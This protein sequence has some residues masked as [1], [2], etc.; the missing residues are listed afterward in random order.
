M[1]VARLVRRPSLDGPRVGRLDPERG[2]VSP[3]EGSAARLAEVD[4]LAAALGREPSERESVADGEVER[5]A[6]GGCRECRTRDDGRDLVA[7]RRLG[8]GRSG[9]SEY[10]EGGSHVSV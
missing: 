2:G 3:M 7:R 6:D 8:D 10:E 4:Q 1:G 5:G 9:Q